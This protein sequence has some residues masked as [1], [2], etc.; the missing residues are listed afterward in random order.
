MQTD[1]APSDVPL[2]ELKE[3][4]TNEQ[5]QLSEQGQQIEI[6]DDGLTANREMMGSGE[7]EWEGG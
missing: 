5:Q 2:V 4:A 6:G 7:R 3:R 1:E